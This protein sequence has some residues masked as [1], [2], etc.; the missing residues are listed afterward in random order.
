MFRGALISIALFPL[1]FMN[2]A[3]ARAESA[4]DIFQFYCVQCHGVK[5][6]G[7]GPNAEFLSTTPRDFTNAVEMNKL[8]DKD[9]KI[10]ISNGGPAVTKSALMPPWGK[11][12]GEDDVEKL[13]TLLRK[14]CN[15][16][17]KQG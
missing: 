12:L 1:V 9:I 8:T 6:D 13:T 4:D 17:G 5:G 15:C 3:E 7:K 14:I 10:V 16:P 2:G 11:T